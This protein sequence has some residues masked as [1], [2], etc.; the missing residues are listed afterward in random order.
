MES[1]R[2]QLQQELARLNKLRHRIENEIINCV[3]YVGKWWKGTGEHLMYI[4]DIDGDGH[5]YGYG[6]LPSGVWRG[7]DEMINGNCACTVFNRPNLVEATCLEVSEALIREAK[8][9][10]FIKGVKYKPISQIGP[11][12]NEYYVGSHDPEVTKDGFQV[13]IGMQWIFVGGE[14]AGVI[15]EDKLYD[16]KEAH[17]NGAEIEIK[18][19]DGTWRPVVDPSWDERNEYR[20]RPEEKPKVGDVVKAWFDNNER[21][22]I[23]RIVSI[24]LGFKYKYGVNIPGLVGVGDTLYYK[25]ARTIT[26]EEVI[27]LLFKHQN[28]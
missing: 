17:K 14:W 16:L 24:N 6:F 12:S 21:Y 15:E 10:G 28:K 27:E 11:L 22:V 4:T 9:R 8:R 5:L 2:E 19:N 26:K 7:R 20:V 23:G 25:N 13:Y 1:K 3:D 18:W